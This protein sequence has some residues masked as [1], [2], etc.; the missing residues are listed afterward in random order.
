MIAASRFPDCER[1]VTFGVC[2]NKRLDNVYV[3]SARSMVAPELAV[4]T[5]LASSEVFETLIVGPVANCKPLQ[6]FVPAGGGVGVGVGLGVGAG[7]GG[8]T[9]RASV[10][11]VW[12]EEVARL[13]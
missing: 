1:R 7:A 3:P 12:S 10:A 8:G 6:A 9:G 2:I 5:A 13:L 4:E 11:N